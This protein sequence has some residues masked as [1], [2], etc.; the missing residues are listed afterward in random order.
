MNKGLEMIEA[1][2]LFDAAPAQVDVLV[3]PQ[4]V[5]HSLVEYQDGSTLAQLGPPDMRTPIACALA[6]PDRLPWDAPRLDLAAVGSLTFEAPDLERFPALSLARQ[7]LTTGGAAPAV[8]NAANEAAVDAFLAGRLGFL[9]IA[10]VVADTL[11]Q[12]SAGLGGSAG[13]GGSLE[14]ALAIDL[15]ARCVAQDAVGRHWALN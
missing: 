3:H 8:L 5:I 2:Y 13:D 7:A 4:S 14:A 1:A 9:N 6:W 12:M 11:H 10:T 15:E